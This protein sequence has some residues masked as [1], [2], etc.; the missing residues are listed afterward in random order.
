MAGIEQR[1]LVE[2]LIRDDG[3][4]DE[5]AHLP[6]SDPPDQCKSQRRKR[7]GDDSFNEIATQ[8]DVEEDA[9]KQER[10]IEEYAAVGEASSFASQE[11]P[12]IPNTAL[13]TQSSAASHGWAP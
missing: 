5:C 9:A 12:K 10:G 7:G 8:C 6:T 13:A 11:T 1:R 3:D 4:G 2:V